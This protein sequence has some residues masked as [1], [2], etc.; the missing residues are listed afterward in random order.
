MSK[1]ISRLGTMAAGWRTRSEPE[2]LSDWSPLFCKMMAIN[3]VETT[4]KRSRWR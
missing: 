4:V 2:T 1:L 3:L